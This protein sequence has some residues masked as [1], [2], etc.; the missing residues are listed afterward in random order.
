MVHIKFIYKECFLWIL[1]SYT[2]LLLLVN[3]LVQAAAWAIYKQEHAETLAALSI[4]DTGLGKYEDKVSKNQRKTFINY[5]YYITS[6]NT[7]IW[8]TRS[9]GHLNIFSRTC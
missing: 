2:I 3:T 1:N 6:T 4:K 5:S 9:L 8:R 7:N